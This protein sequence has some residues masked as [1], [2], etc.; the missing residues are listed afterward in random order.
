MQ[1]NAVFLGIGVSLGLGKSI[2]ASYHA[3]FTAPVKKR[4]KPWAILEHC[5]VSGKDIR[6]FQQY[7]LWI[8]LK[9][10]EAHCNGLQFSTV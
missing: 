8:V 6:E 2:G 7:L 1:I 3:G 4:K 5:H 9:R 10:T